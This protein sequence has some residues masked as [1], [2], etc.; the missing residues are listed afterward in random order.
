MLKWF[1]TKS[2]IGAELVI[3]LVL[4]F[5]RP[6]L[7]VCDNWFAANSCSRK[8]ATKSMGDTSSVTFNTESQS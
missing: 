3:R 1:K 8:F 5:K 7:I 2:G 6:V 4:R